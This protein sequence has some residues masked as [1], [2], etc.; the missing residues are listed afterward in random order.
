MGFSLL[1]SVVLLFLQVQA[2]NC[3]Y[4]ERTAPALPR[5]QSLACTLLTLDSTVTAILHQFRFAV[6]LRCT[7][8]VRGSAKGQ[9]A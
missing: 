2:L 6:A 1:C 3:Q 7:G 5:G 4:L 8:A 9:D